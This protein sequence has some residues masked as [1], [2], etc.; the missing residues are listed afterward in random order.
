MLAP[1]AALT[2]C[3]Q[4]ASANADAPPAA[5]AAK[6]PLNYNRDV[7]PILSDKC[8]GCHG[9]DDKKADAAGLRLDQ[10]E[11]AYAVHKKSGHIPIVPGKPE[12]SEAWKRIMS[13]DPDEVMPR[14]SSHKTL[15]ADEKAMLKR[16]IEEGAKYEKHWAFVA[17]SRPALPAVKNAAWVKNP[18]DL[19]ILAKLETEGFGPSPEADKETL[20][21]RASLD[22]T[23]LPP[24]PEETDAFLADASPYAYE[25][26]VDRLLASPRFGERMASPWLDAARYADSHG[27]LHNQKRSMWPWRDWVIQTFN[28]DKP[29]DQFITEQLAGDL[30]PNA[31]E[32]QKLA[33]GFNR[34]HPI[35][36]EGGTVAEEYLN[37]YACDRVQTV[38][39]AMLGLSIGCC[40]CHDHK[41]D[42]LPTEDF[43][44]L[45]AYFNSSSEKHH[46]DSASRAATPPFITA[47]SPLVPGG[48]KVQVMVMDELPKPVPTF[49]LSRGQYDLPDKDRPVTRHP[50]R[51]LNP[52]PAGAPAIAWAWPNG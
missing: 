43:Y 40:R 13:T 16:W 36:T 42:P 14:P 26:Q 51:V 29:Y 31:T 3:E 27:Y 34:N 2:A 30:L 38:G 49:V 23:G 52:M 19:F 46:P 41:F 9:P 10:P 12:A 7:R 22:L 39:S 48:P 24:T 47:T 15:S 28:A 5:P 17:P 6:A 33:T 1:L 44:A 25:K 50:P 20:L 45:K 21:R 35:T 8:I 32:T 37:E 18:I 4:K 11:T